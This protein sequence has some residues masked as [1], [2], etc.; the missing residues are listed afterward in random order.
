MLD[1]YLKQTITVS[2]RVRSFGNVTS[3]ISEMSTVTEDNQ[4]TADKA[5]SLIILTD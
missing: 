2:I 5:D 1:H 4:A 3:L